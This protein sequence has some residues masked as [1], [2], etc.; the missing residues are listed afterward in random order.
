LLA[1][2]SVSALAAASNVQR[3]VMFIQTSSERLR[4]AA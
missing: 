2:A 4:R 1:A 3:I